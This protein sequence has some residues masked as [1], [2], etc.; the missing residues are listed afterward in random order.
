[1]IL[2]VRD[3]PEK[4]V[5]SVRATL[6]RFKFDD[7]SA[8]HEFRESFYGFLTKVYGADPREQETD[9]RKLYLDWNEELKRSIKKENLLVFNVKEGWG[10]LCKFLGVPEPEQPFPNLNSKESFQQKYVE[11]LLEKKD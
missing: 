2:T 9:V 11:V 7:N 1:M 3:N 6:F 4:W 8:R 10:P 5:E